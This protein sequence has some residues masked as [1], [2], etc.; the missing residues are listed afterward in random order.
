MHQ[1]RIMKQNSEKLLHGARLWL[2]TPQIQKVYLWV[3]QQIRA[4]NVV[5]ANHIQMNPVGAQS[6]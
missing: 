6:Q 3:A 5:A 2:L 4:A 1:S